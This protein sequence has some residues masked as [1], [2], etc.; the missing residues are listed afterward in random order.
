MERTCMVMNDEFKKSGDIE[1]GILKVV[2][3]LLVEI[4]VQ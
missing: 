1:K 3:Y 2:D 4:D